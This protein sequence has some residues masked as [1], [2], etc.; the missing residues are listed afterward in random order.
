[1]FPV[2]DFHATLFGT[3]RNRFQ[4]SIVENTPL[5]TTI[6]RVV[7]RDV[8]IGSNAEVVYSLSPGT[9]AA[10]GDVF[11]V[12][13]LTG[14]VVVTG[15]VDYE[16]APVYHLIVAA[17]DRGPEPLA[18][19]TTVVV[20]VDDV[21]DNA[22]RATVSTLTASA[23]DAAS[24]P[25]N[26][27]PGTFVAHVLVHDPDR[28]ASGRFNCTAVSLTSSD[29]R[30]ISSASFPGGVEPSRQ[31][32]LERMLSA[33]YHL[34]TSASAALDRERTDVYA[35]GIA[36]IDGGPVPLWSIRELT[37]EVSDVNDNW[38]VFDKEEYV[39]E[40]YENNYNGLVVAQVCM[41]Y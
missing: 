17:R 18:A 28:G 29:G 22:P 15:L 9:Q 32:R 2:V 5:G 24:V 16:R 38:P 30:R 36:C 13:Q 8:D 41:L 4:V 35:I 19:E 39:A 3:G 23:A 14:D 40:I 37:V 12:D 11:G 10:Y 20:K 21:N 7:A 1:M 25:E 6:A 26:A 27:G 31:F 33:E 34:V